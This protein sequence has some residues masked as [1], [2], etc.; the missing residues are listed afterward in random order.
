MKAQDD[1]P[2]KRIYY[3]TENGQDALDKWLKQPQTDIEQVKSKAMLRL[4]FG[5]MNDLEAV[6][7][8]LKYKKAL[9]EQKLAD[10]RT[11]SVEVI[12]EAE[13]RTPNGSY[14]RVFWDATRDF[15]E[16]YEMMVV[17]WLEDTIR[18]LTQLQEKET[19]THE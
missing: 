16:Q 3:I 1:R 9:H 5:G 15:G 18:Q 19:Q 2:D 14:H 10:Y 7:T 11:V 8:E 12:D 4:F 6:L 13:Q 17:Q